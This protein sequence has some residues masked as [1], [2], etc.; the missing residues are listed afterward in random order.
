M[1]EDDE[2]DEVDDHAVEGVVHRDADGVVEDD[3]LLAVEVQEQPHC[4][5]RDGKRDQCRV[6]EGHEE[7]QAKYSQRGGQVKWKPRNDLVG[8]F[9][10]DDI[11]GV[12]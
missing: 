5:Y 3:V 6:H 2:R 11:M 9:L 12:F 1:D 4:E 8:L 7:L 10:D